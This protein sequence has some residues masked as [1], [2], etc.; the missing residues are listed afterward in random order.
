MA[1]AQVVGGVRVD[2]RRTAGFQI[3]GEHSAP[4][5][6]PVGRDWRRGQLSPDRQAL[7]AG[8]E[9]AVFAPLFLAGFMTDKF[10][11]RA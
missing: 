9:T 1:A 3:A 11:Y 6:G 10:S 7:A 8:F 5:I 2:R 4:P